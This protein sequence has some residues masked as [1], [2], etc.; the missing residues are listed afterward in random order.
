MIA[1]FMSRTREETIRGGR[2]M[3]SATDRWD[4]KK[5]NQVKGARYQ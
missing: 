2:E 5:W 4:N 3:K 1:S